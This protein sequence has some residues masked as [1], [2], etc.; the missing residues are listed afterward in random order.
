MTWGY[1]LLG[2]FEFVRRKV[3]VT[4]ACLWPRTSIALETHK[5]TKILVLPGFPTVE[6]R[7]LGL[8]NSD[9]LSP[10]KYS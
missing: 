8:G 9:A 10:L 1:D 6:L 3:T 4:W 5:F 2:N 7:P